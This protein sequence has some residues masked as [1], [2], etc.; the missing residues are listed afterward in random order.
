MQCWVGGMPR[1]THRE[2][3]ALF[4]TYLQENVIFETEKSV[5]PR[6]EQNKYAKR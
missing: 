6:Q 2:L 1:V 5:Y 4:L 3:G